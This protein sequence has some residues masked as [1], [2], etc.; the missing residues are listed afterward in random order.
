MYQMPGSAPVVRLMMYPDGARLGA[1]PI[2]DALHRAFGRLAA[3]LDDVAGARRLL[4][5]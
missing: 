3:L 5:G 4:L 2:A 1:A